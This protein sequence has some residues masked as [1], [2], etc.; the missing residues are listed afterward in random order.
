MLSEGNRPM[1][2]LHLQDVP[3][4]VYECLRQRAEAHD[5]TVEAEALGVLERGLVAEPQ[6]WLLPQN[7]QHRC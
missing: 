3:T 1:P 7:L 4:R 6:V 5:R 2:V